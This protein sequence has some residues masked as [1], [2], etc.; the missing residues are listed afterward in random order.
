MRPFRRRALRRAAAGDV[1]AMFALGVEFVESGRLEQA[2]P[3][4]R[5]AAGNG[6]TGAMF[7]LGELL[8]EAGDQDEAQHWFAR[9]NELTADEP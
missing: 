9:F 7:D 4:L 2:E 3:W 6:D 1:E 8:A 5:R